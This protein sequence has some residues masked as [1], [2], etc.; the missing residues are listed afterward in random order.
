MTLLGPFCYPL[1]LTV[2][3]IRKEEVPYEKYK[4]DWQAQERVGGVRYGNEFF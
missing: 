2:I 1:C 3:Y 4:T